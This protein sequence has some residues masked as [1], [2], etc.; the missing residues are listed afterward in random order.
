MNLYLRQNWRIWNHIRFH[1]LGTVTFPEDKKEKTEKCDEIWMK[2]LKDETIVRHVIHNRKGKGTDKYTS[3]V[4][5]DGNYCYLVHVMRTEYNTDNTDIYMIEY[6]ESNVQ[7][8]IN[9]SK[10][11]HKNINKIINHSVEGAKKLNELIN[12]QEIAKE[13][14]AKVD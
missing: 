9:L 6:S 13:I 5:S 4:L 12:K 14:A 7:D 1:P 8:F 11:I 3:T 10:F 2:L